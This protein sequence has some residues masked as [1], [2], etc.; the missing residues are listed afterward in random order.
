MKQENL[1]LVGEII[2]A[3]GNSWFL[4]RTSE[5]EL[6]AQVGG[7]MKLFNIRVAVGDKVEVMVSPYDYTKGKIVKRL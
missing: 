3:Y 1:L 7:R 2:T 4:V 6:K 5:H